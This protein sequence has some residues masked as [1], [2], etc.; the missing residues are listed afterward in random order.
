[1]E[2]IINKDIREYKVKDIGP[3]SLGQFAGLAVGAAM[4]YGVY[5]LE[6]HYLHIE[7]INDIQIASIIVAAL[8]GIVFGF[9]RPYGISFIKFLRTVFFENF[10]NPKIRKYESDFDFSKVYQLTEEDMM[11]EKELKKHNKRKLTREEKH[12]IKKWKGYK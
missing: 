10:T 3:F 8:P 2:V 11:S 5:F 12:E 4:G 9:V 7:G 6:K 1:M